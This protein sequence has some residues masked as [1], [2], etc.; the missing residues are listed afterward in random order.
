MVRDEKILRLFLG[1][2]TPRQFPTYLLTQAISQKAKPIIKLLLEKGADVNQRNSD[3]VPPLHLAC[4]S[5]DCDEVKMFLDKKANAKA[6]YNSGQGPLF[7]ALLN[8]S[9]F[10]REPIMHYLLAAGAAVDQPDSR[11][12]YPFHYAAETNLVDTMAFLLRSGASIDVRNKNGATPLMS[13]ISAGQKEAVQWLVS[14]GAKLELYNLRGQ[15]PLYLADFF[16]SE[17]ILNILLAAGAP[18]ESGG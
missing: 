10:H 8:P 17:K 12:Y 13:A 11:G 2:I 4:K 6:L 7:Y 16:A 15:S 18:K 9:N 14:N 5:L 1:K 3:G